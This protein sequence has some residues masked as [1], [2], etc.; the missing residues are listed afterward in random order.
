MRLYGTDVYNALRVV[1]AIANRDTFS[2]NRSFISRKGKGEDEG[3]LNA[4]PVL[5]CLIEDDNEVVVKQEN[6][7]RELV[8]YKEDLSVLVKHALKL[9]D[10]FE[11]GSIVRFDPKD[12]YQ[13]T[14][15]FKLDK[16]LLQKI[17]DGES[18]GE[19]LD[20]MQEMAVKTVKEKIENIRFELFKTPFRGF[21]GLN[22]P[23]VI[24]TAVKIRHAK[25][26]LSNLE[27][28]LKEIR[29]AKDEKTLLNLLE[30]A[31]GSKIPALHG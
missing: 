31:D 8:A 14:V 4:Q 29:N 13:S 5:E 30:K 3:W 9:L 10:Q 19:P 22:S 16:K 7:R 24:S 18:I 15:V 17:A 2:I 11:D 23:E 25:E 1:V 28:I 21:P 27:E 20:V 12:R 6:W 26:T